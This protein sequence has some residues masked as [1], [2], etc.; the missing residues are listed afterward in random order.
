MLTSRSW[1][2]LVI[3]S[4]L[5]LRLLWIIP[6]FE[7]ITLLQVSYWSCCYSLR[8]GLAVEHSHLNYT[9]H[10]VQSGNTPLP[11]AFSLKNQVDPFWNKISRATTFILF[12]FSWN[13]ILLTHQYPKRFFSIR[14]CV[15]VTLRA[16][17]S[18]ILL[19]SLC[20]SGGCGSSILLPWNV[21]KP[22]Q[23]HNLIQALHFAGLARYF[24]D[25]KIKKTERI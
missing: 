2:L 11:H 9:S 24:P 16:M 17:L 4:L 18:I 22:R 25:W 6:I 20:C 13:L 15:K 10:E 12:N 14:A 5:H 1:L 19:H 23:I 8:V 7:A 21:R 3:T